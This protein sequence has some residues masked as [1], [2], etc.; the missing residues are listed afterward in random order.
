MPPTSAA[1]SQPNRPIS[2]AARVL[3]ASSCQAQ[4]RTIGR[5]GVLPIRPVRDLIRQHTYIA[6]YLL[7]IAFITGARPH[8][9]HV[10]TFARFHPFMQIL[11]AD[12]SGRIAVRAK[13][14]RRIRFPFFFVDLRRNSTPV[15]CGDRGSA[16]PVDHARSQNDRADHSEQQL[17]PLDTRLDDKQRQ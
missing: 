13:H 9:Q 10:Q 7:R 17:G 16:C 4:Y 8:I 2:S 6:R 12:R 14:G 5:S 15:P 1:A 3:V 11:N